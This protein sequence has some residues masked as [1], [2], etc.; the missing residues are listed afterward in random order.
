MWPALR[1]AWRTHQDRHMATG[2]INQGTVS[3]MR[4]PHRASPNANVRDFAMSVKQ[5][6]GRRTDRSSSLSQSLDLL[7][8]KMNS[9]DPRRKRVASRSRSGTRRFS[10]GRMQISAFV[11][12]QAIGVYSCLRE[13]RNHLGGC[14]SKY[15]SND[16]PVRPVCPTNNK[17]K[18]CGGGPIG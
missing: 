14:S 3:V 4:V 17:R 8:Y 18:H 16:G 9:R 2:R 11:H 7:T 15:T 10:A 13:C 1:S 6:A 5:F 12:N